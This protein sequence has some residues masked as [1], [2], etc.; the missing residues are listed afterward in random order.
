MIKPLNN[1]CLIE[2]IDEYEGVLRNTADENVQKGVL[3]NFRLANDHLTTSTGYYIKEEDVQAYY[4]ELTSMLGE[5][6]YWQE[7]ADAGAKF[8]IEGKQF[9]L[10]PFYRL[11][12][13]EESNAEEAK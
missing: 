3:R 10:V 12:G 13:F 4:N 1:N 11:I 2:V 9:V 8:T 7:Y 5:T 6:V